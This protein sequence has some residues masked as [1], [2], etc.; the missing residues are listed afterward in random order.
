MRLAIFAEVHGD[1]VGG[2]NFEK[3]VDAARERRAIETVA[4]KLR[5]ENV[6]HALDVVAGARMSLQLHAERAQFFDP[7]PDLLPRYA[8]F[9]GDFRAADDDGGVFGEQREERVNAAVGGAREIRDSLGR[10]WELGR[11]LDPAADNKR[12]TRNPHRRTLRTGR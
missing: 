7:A 9:F 1:R 6:R 12:G 8:D 3:M 10:H 5:D 4:Q 2:V 11:I